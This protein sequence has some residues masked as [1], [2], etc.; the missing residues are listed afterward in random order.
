MKIVIIGGGPAGMLAA[1]AASKSNIYNV[2][3]VKEPSQ[4]IL[5][6]KNEKLGKKL[7][8]TGKGRC[9]LTNDCERDEFFKNIVRNPKFL[10][11][12]FSAFSNK[13]LESFVEENGCKIKIERGNRVFPHSDKS[14]DVIDAFKNALKE[15]KVKIKLNTEVKSIA[16]KDD[17]F[18]ITTNNEKIHA[19]RVII[20]TGGMS[21]KST[22]STGDGYK[23][24]KSFDI[25]VVSQS[26]SLVPFNVKEV[27]ECKD[28]QGLTLKNIGIKIF[29]LNNT[30]KVIYDDFGELLFTHFGLSGPVILSASCYLELPYDSDDELKH[31]GIS[32]KIDSI[33]LSIDLKP[34]LSSEQLD[35]RLIRELEENKNKQLKSVIES[36]LPSSMVDV[37][38]DRLNKGDK[39]PDSLKIRELASIKNADVPKELR[40]SIVALLKD[41]RYIIESKRGFNEAIITRGGV[42]VKE[43]NPKTMESKKVS[44]LYFA[45]EVIDIDA[46]TGGFNI[47][48]ASSTGYLAGQ[49]A[50]NNGLF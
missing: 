14:Y 50:A 1:I 49:N 30:K 24:A 27:N 2:E 35:Q 9:N 13:N 6:E 29:D 45:G 22:G 18:I 11:S 37:F 3:K 31:S 21:Y 48:I 38:I 32:N 8:I 33:V 44:G 10:F 46:M 19:D 40:R 16:I 42:D 39:L 43:I 26:P 36:L 12:A 15:A 28:M 23:F 5:L 47:Q 41:F 20:A 17:E 4:V 25:D 34:A 7:F